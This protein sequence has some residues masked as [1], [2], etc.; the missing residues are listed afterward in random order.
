MPLS[1]E[2]KPK[3]RIVHE[4]WL[5]HPVYRVYGVRNFGGTLTGVA[6]FHSAHRWAD[7]MNQKLRNEARRNA[8]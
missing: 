6:A 2:Q 1:T 8:L 4:P 3:I 5:L 7:L